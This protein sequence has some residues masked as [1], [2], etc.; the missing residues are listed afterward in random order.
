MRDYLKYTL[1][2]RKKNLSNFKVKKF[3]P[4]EFFERYVFL[5]AIRQKY[6]EIS[7]KIAKKSNLE[8]NNENEGTMNIIIKTIIE[9]IFLVI[10]DYNDYNIEKN[11]Q[12]NY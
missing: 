2:I 12:I 6:S 3:R 8:S 11:I 1:E 5:K 10:I 9:M 4:N 7:E